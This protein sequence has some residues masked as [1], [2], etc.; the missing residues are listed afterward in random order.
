M[1]NKNSFKLLRASI[2]STIAIILLLGSRNITL[3]WSAFNISEFS[4]SF[5][6]AASNPPS[7]EDKNPCSSPITTCT[8]SNTKRFRLRSGTPGSSAFSY[9]N[10]TANWTASAYGS[11]TATTM[12]WYVYI[13]N[14]GVSGQNLA[15]VYYEV[16]PGGSNPGF[17]IVVNQNNWEGQKVYL[18][19]SSGNNNSKVRT[20]DRCV[21]GYACDARWIFVDAARVQP[22]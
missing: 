1:F 16:L 15:A 11:S 13:P 4:G 17:S 14:D 21:T 22:N 9:W 12:Y 6:Y 8:N 10:Y 7:N 18:G 5:I 3:A 20:S 2:F 19:N